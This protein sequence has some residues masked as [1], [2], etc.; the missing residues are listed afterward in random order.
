MKVQEKIFVTTLTEKEIE[1]IT[2]ALHKIYK[3][4]KIQNSDKDA[5]VYVNTTKT[6]ELRILRNEF[7]SLIGR[8]Y[9]GE[10]A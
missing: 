1:Y 5:N 8:A 2:E 3:E 7:A 9:M 4:M 6:A 10:D